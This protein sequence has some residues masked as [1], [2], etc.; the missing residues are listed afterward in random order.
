MA[1][2]ETVSILAFPG[3]PHRLTLTNLHSFPRGLCHEFASCDYAVANVIYDARLIDIIISAAAGTVVI[4][5][6]ESAISTAAIDFLT[7]FDNRRIY[8]AEQKTFQHLCNSG[9]GFD[10]HGWRD[11]AINSHLTLAAKEFAKSMN[12]AGQQLFGGRKEPA[13]GGEREAKLHSVLK[14]AAKSLLAFVLLKCV[15][16]GNPDGLARERLDIDAVADE[17]CCGI[18]FAADPPTPKIEMRGATCE[19]VPLENAPK[20][21]IR[22]TKS[23]AIRSSDPPTPTIETPLYCGRAPAL[24][25]EPRPSQALKI[26]TTGRAQR[27]PIPAH[28]AKPSGAPQS[29]GTFIADCVST[30]EPH[31]STPTPSSDP[32]S[33]F[34][35]KNVLEAAPGSEFQAKNPRD[36]PASCEFLEKNGSDGFEHDEPSHDCEYDD[37]GDDYGDFIA[38][39]IECSSMR[40]GMEAVVTPAA[41]PVQRGV[42][43]FWAVLGDVTAKMLGNG[44]LTIGEN[45]FCLCRPCN[46]ALATDTDCMMH[47]WKQHCM[48]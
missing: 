28:E 34:Q 45:G 26:E 1:L 8:M 2:N 22:S 17:F 47:V 32:K 38:S 11:L 16:G 20:I 27:S 15:A 25:I 13:S 7:L 35:A 12:R 48:A 19:G 36:L 29:T 46:A 37:S 33:T 6:V 3:F 44:D 30:S 9:I 23:V 21:E 43:D 41:A 40:P 14:W 18:P 39:S 10:F 5:V 24:R 4:G 31:L 42:P